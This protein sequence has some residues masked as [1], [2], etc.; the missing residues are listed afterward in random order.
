M[1]IRE[2]VIIHSQSIIPKLRFQRNLHLLAFWLKMLYIST[3]NSNCCAPFVVVCHACWN[4]QFALDYRL[5]R[6]ES[7]PSSTL[8]YHLQGWGHWGED[9]R[10]SCPSQIHRQA[11]DN[12]KVR[13]LRE[14]QLMLL[15]FYKLMLSCFILGQ[16]IH[17]S[18]WENAYCRSAS[19]GKF[20]G[21]VFC[22]VLWNC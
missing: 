14:W 21:E 15:L 7:S 6:W 19:G 8:H 13:I 12:L 17:G 3:F 5:Y 4:S 11:G 16:Q 20:E 22:E 2:S 18:N 9:G 1:D 10:G